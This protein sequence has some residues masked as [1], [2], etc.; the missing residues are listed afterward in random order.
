MWINAART[1]DT[2]ISAAI[3]S[4]PGLNPDQSK[5]LFQFLSQLTAGGSNKQDGEEANASAAYM[6][7]I[8]PVL[9]SIYCLCALGHDAWILDSGASE[10]M[11]SEQTRLYELCV[12]QQPILVN[13]PNGSQIRVTKQQA[14][15]KQRLGLKPCTSC[16]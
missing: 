9:K 13:L 15:D 10:H 14:K 4:L 7:G 2:A 12:L 11:C 16:S 5:H 6:V 3:P 8:N 1:E